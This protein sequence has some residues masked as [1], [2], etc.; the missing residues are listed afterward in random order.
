MQLRNMKIGTR[1]TSVFA[2]LGA[3]V[4][5]MG[6]I[7][8]YETR[9]MDTATDEIRVT[10]M[11]AVVAL[12]DISTDL[13]RARAITLRAALDDNPAERARNIDL[14]NGIN[15]RLK[16]SLKDYEDTIIAADDRAL[17]N[18]FNSAHQQYLDLQNRVLQAIAA[19]RMDEAKQQI[20]GP[21]TQY[22]DT[23][24][25]AMTALIA[26]NGKGAEDASQRSSDVADEALT[27]IIASLVIIML[28]LAAIATLLTRSIVVP[29]ADAVAVAE[30]VATGDLTQDIRVLGHDEPAL[31]LRALSRMQGNLRDTI[32]KIAAS[33]DQ[34]ASASEELHTVTEDTSRGLHQQSA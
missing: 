16:G 7:T 15:E 33:S 2:L 29:L 11:P 18:A 27:A 28:A 6:L 22:A 12:G 30:R 9:Q 3:L 8:L 23:M 21:L 1:A 20:S 13:G 26:Y 17:F 14:A 19:G 32:R 4:L 10:W 5:A 25:K 24:M 34:L 31:L